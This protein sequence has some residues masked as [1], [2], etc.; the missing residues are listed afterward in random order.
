[1][2]SSPP[3]PE[4][5]AHAGWT[6]LSLRL[7]LT[8]YVMI[9]AALIEVAV[10]VGVLLQQGRSLRR[11]FDELLLE[12]A[13]RVHDAWR[14]SQDSPRSAPAAPP[15]VVLSGSHVDVLPGPLCAVYD[16]QC[17]ALAASGNAALDPVPAGVSAALAVRRP[18]FRDYTVSPPAPATSYPVR[19]VAQ[20][21][22]VP[23]GHTVVVVVA[24]P[25]AFL[26]EF[27]ARRNDT[28]VIAVS[29]GVVAAGAGG[30][31]LTGLALAPIRRLRQF[32]AGLGPDS[33]HQRVAPEPAAE[34][35]QLQAELQAAL[36]RLE[37]GYEAQDRLIVHLSHELKTPVA[38]VL[39]EAQTLGAEPGPD[40]LRHFVRSAEEEMRR[41]ARLVDSL[42]RLARTRRAPSAGERSRCGV[43]DLVLQSVENCRRL[44]QRRG[45][46]LDVQ[47]PDQDGD[48]DLAVAGE[49]DLLCAMLDTLLEKRL[50]AARRGAQVNVCVRREDG[51]VSFAIAA[52]ADADARADVSGTPRAPSRAPFD[53]TVAS[54][55]AELHG[56]AL[57]VGTGPAG[58][59]P[60]TVRLP[61]AVP[62]TTG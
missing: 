47:L 53:I 12:N 62:V 22:P 24:R 8:L 52:T 40:R 39:L 13:R 58:G 61:V 44:A 48:L 5:G 19:S 33:L 16:E 51:L 7:R 32:V 9:I 23:G 56:G 17:L 31:F 11:S 26:E 46:G 25:A 60:V 59:E 6:R 50:Y 38:T 45:I 21:F 29:M 42:L 34:V 10:G 1:M 28:L 14:G 30:W 49:P 35:R 36:G 20:A 37:D 4:R 57:H 43:A 15:P 41:L 3:E 27:I 2:P 54:S 55:I 18:Q